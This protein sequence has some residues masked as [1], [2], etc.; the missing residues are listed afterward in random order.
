LKKKKKELIKKKKKK[1]K[2][3]KKKK[4]SYPIIIKYLNKSLQKQRTLTFTDQD[5]KDANQ[6][7]DDTKPILFSRYTPLGWDESVYKESTDEEWIRFLMERAYSR[8]EFQKQYRS[9]LKTLFGEVLKLKNRSANAPLWQRRT[10]YPKEQKVTP[11]KEQPQTFAAYIFKD[12]IGKL[13]IDIGSTNQRQW[14]A[15]GTPYVPLDQRLEECGM[16]YFYQCK[17]SDLKTMYEEA[18]SLLMKNQLR[19]LTPGMVMAKVYEE[20]K[21]GGSQKEKNTDFY[22]HKLQT[23]RKASGG[24]NPAYM[25]A[26]MYAADKL[27]RTDDTATGYVKG[28]KSEK[29]NAIKE[30]PYQV[31]VEGQS[32]L[33]LAATKNLP[34]RDTELQEISSSRT[35]T[36]DRRQQ[37]FAQKAVAA[38]AKL[39]QEEQQV[40]GQ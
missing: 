16:G 27:A 6:D 34:A 31:G 37:K 30:H 22:L 29:K 11:R 19:V 1:L 32:R 3:K 35:A 8:Q 10:Y 14:N 39:N 25:T 5:F 36:S 38:L 24:T 28:G 20:S 12:L 9:E 40:R 2:K 18:R 21:E 13:N 26:L 23:L 7:S 4:I 33:P 17:Q 15:D